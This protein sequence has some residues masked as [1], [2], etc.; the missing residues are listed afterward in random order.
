MQTTFPIH[1]HQSVEVKHRDER[2]FRE[3]TIMMGKTMSQLETLGV[4]SKTSSTL[5]GL[6]LVKSLA[7]RDPRT[8][9]K[10]RRLFPK[11]SVA[12]HNL[13]AKD[14]LPM[15]TLNSCHQTRD[16]VKRL[17]F[18]NFRKLQRQVR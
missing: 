8:S 9:P 7:K 11:L 6:R 13:G 10:R 3:L 1:E 16:L 14:L 5:N 12:P 15:V 18:G 17:A 4:P 2:N